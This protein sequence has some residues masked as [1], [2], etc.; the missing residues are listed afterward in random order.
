M[1]D[2][3]TA[4]YPPPSKRPR[5]LV[6]CRRCKQR[7][8]KC[9]GLEPSCS[10]CLRTG[11]ECRYVGS[12][13]PTAA[14]TKIYVK[15]LEHRV[16]ELESILSANGN[17][18]VAGDH[19]ERVRPRAD[20]IDA[21]SSAVCDLSLNACGF[22]V[23]GSSSL[24]IGSLLA[25]LVQSGQRHSG[26]RPISRPRRHLAELEPASE[27]FPQDND[28]HVPDISCFDDRNLDRLFDA[29]LN[30]FSS[31]LPVIHTPVLQK[32]HERRTEITDPFEASILHLV[33]AIGGRCLELAGMARNFTF[34]ADQ[35]Y[36]AAMEWR[37]VIIGHCDRRTVIF[38]ALAVSYCLRAP[39]APGPWMMIGHAV[40]L[41]V[42]LGLHR[43]SNALQ[44]DPQR[45]LDTRAFWAC[46]CLDVDTTI[47]SG[48]PPSI[49]NRDIDVSLPLDMEESSTSIQDF[50]NAPTQNGNK[51]RR[52]TTSLS[53]FILGIE[54]RKII[55]S[56]QHEIYRV[57]RNVNASHELFDMFLEELDLWKADALL[58]SKPTNGAESSVHQETD[59]SRSPIENPMLIIQYHNATRLLLFPQLTEPQVHTPYLRRCATA[60]IDVCQRYKQAHDANFQICY[61]PHSIQS[62]FLAGLTL[63]YCMWLEP[64]EVPYHASRGAITDCSIMLYVMAERW[65][66]AQRYRNIFE[67]T[68]ISML[69]IIA[70]DTS[71]KT[72]AALDGI[73]TDEASFVGSL[74]NEMGG[75]ASFCLSHILQSVSNQRRTETAP[76]VASISS[77]V[78]DI[79]PEPASTGQDLL[80]T[81]HFGSSYNGLLWSIDFSGT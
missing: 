78:E 51:P 17:I 60:C 1:A 38:L 50:Q 8:T 23:G 13:G 39:R 45:E 5:V 30:F 10:S 41:C 25:S 47:A 6:A 7:K 4:D 19:W 57:D 80:D 20:S 76:H 32:F 46:Y 64:R 27:P 37:D 67:R 9:D 75:S 40:K 36:E 65:P 72:C 35:H 24:A 62:V 81:A 14:E 71:Q 33:Y 55:S 22:Y 79:I 18:D 61:S 69:K 15:T 54:L 31:Q 43:K 59:G 52:L 49:S 70:G 28:Y 3:P 77:P 63:I 68:R 21:L 42:S 26:N 16:A 44:P 12:V 66:E 56:I 73:N 34:S 58:F 2:E 53:Y 29:Y 74:G 48:R 11:S